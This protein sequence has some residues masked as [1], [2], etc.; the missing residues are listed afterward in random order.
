MDNST[1]Y[2]RNADLAGLAGIL[3][4]ISMA[5]LALAFRGKKKGKRK[6]NN[7]FNGN[8]RLVAQEGSVKNSY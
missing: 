1:Q 7:S 6:M 2:R 5:A 8:H 4:I 3:A